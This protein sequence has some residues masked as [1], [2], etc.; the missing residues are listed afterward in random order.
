MILNPRRN[1]LNVVRLLLAATVIVSHAYPLGGY[2]VE[3]HIGKVHLGTL[4]VYGFFAVSGYLITRSRLRVGSG[5]FLW[6]RF[7][8]IFPAYWVSMVV[9]VAVLAPLTWW[10]R[11]GS[12][13]AYP[14]HSAG[15]YM[16]VNAALIRRQLGVSGTLTNALGDWEGTTWT[17]AYEF[18]C[19][20]AVAVLGAIG[21]LRRKPIVVLGVLAGV[22]CLGLRPGDGHVDVIQ[23]MTLAQF[24]VLFAAG[25]CAALF[26]DHVPMSRLYAAG[27]A[28]VAVTACF[29]PYRLTAPL[30]A[31]PMTYL[32]LWLGARL[33]F[34]GAFQRNDISYG[35][36]IY[37]WTV[38]QLIIGF[39]Y[40]PS[41]VLTDLAVTAVLTTL[42][43]AASWFAIERPTLR[44]KNATLRRRPE[45]AARALPVAAMA[46]S[47]L[48][49]ESRSRVDLE[50]LCE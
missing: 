27:A 32:M 40:R 13:T 38:Q 50:R 31:V 21:L 49:A 16:V 24:G 18:L 23:P 4:A 19:Y 46:A 28:A 20:L 2:G 6:H 47:G 45:R 43:A 3:P 11:H 22:A 30:L 39:G 1:S 12:L 7:L 17:L 36:Y 9:V 33:P 25:G 48:T 35:I 26:A 29:A 5:R 41:S 44:M 14:L 10:H 34:A 15:H 37:G 42:F 8:R